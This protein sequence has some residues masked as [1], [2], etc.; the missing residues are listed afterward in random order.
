MSMFR[1]GLTGK[2]VLSASQDVGKVLRDDPLL[3]L[4]FGMFWIWIWYVFQ[5]PAIGA[6]GAD[7]SPL[8]VLPWVLPLSAYAAGFFILGALYFCKRIIPK[9]RAYKAGIPCLMTVGLAAC[10]LIPSPSFAA[11]SLEV[12]IYAVGSVAMGLSSAFLHVEWGRLSGSL[13]PRCTIV[14]AACG[15]LFASAAIVVIANTPLSVSLAALVAFSWAG[16]A[17]VFRATSRRKG[18]YAQ[19]SHAELRISVKFI[20]TAFTQGCSLGVL[21]IIM[22]KSHTQLDGFAVSALGFSI[23]ALLVVAA[24]LVCKM[25]FNRLIYHIGFPLMALGCLLVALLASAVA[26]GGLVHA[27]GYRFVDIL[28]WALMAYIMK[29]NDMPANWVSSITTC[30]LI[31][32]QFAGTFCG[33]TALTVLGVPQ[34]MSVPCMVIVFVLL[35]CA[36]LATSTHNLRTGWGMV[37]PGESDVELSRFDR[38]CMMIAKE[39]RL[40]EREAEVFSYIAQGFPR[41][42]ICEKL[43]V[44]DGTVKAHTRNIYQKLDIH[45][46]QDAMKLIEAHLSDYAGDDADG[47]ERPVPLV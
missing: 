46:R 1:T 7:S 21:Q 3:F 10:S 12:A 34:G 47:P 13:G 41:K 17:V 9:S 2:A 20:V 37:A 8:G 18:I 42:Y 15:T 36:L 11:S 24:A 39:Y 44:A 23:G 22:F 25:D 28:I 6:L 33:W 5:S 31:L 16:A 43:V 4:G 45:S 40:T 27:A 26:C 38:H 30:W 19:G 14:H 35:L 32:G 29:Y